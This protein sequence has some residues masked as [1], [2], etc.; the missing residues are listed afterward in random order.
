MSRACY[1]LLIDPIVNVRV[2]PADVGHTSVM[3]RRCRPGRMGRERGGRRL[4]YRTDI[5][6][7]I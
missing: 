6:S 4:A 1:R 3:D 7:K 2:P 5:W